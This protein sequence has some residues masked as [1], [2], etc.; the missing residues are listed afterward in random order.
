MVSLMAPCKGRNI[1][2]WLVASASNESRCA[3]APSAERAPLHIAWALLRNARTLYGCASQVGQRGAQRGGSSEADAAGHAAERDIEVTSALAG[4]ATEV[5]EAAPCTI[6]LGESVLASAFWQI[7]CLWD[8]PPGKAASWD[9]QALWPAPPLTLT[10]TGCCCCLQMVEYQ[11][12]LPP[13]GQCV[14]VMA[15]AD[16]SMLHDGSKRQCCSSTAAC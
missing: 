11:D 1:L 7:L 16:S 6:V 10:L 5:R 13:V 12:G 15:H 3:G 14:E 8:Q 2:T 4:S 9:M